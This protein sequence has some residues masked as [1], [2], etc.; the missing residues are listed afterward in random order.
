[1]FVCRSRSCVERN[2]QR[3][4][5]VCI[6]YHVV[7]ILEFGSMQLAVLME[8]SIALLTAR[9]PYVHRTVVS[10]PPSHMKADQWNFMVSLEKIFS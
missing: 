6:H 9:N 1:M 8:S 4:T 10:W 7:L 2:Q 5:K 3:S